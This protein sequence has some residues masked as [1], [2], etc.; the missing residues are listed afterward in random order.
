[1]WNRLELWED[2]LFNSCHPTNVLRFL[3][4]GGVLSGEMQELY[5]MQFTIQDPYFHPEGDVWTHTMLVVEE[6]CK[7]ADREG[8]NYFDRSVLILAAL[9]HDLGKVFTTKVENGRITSHGHEQGG[10]PITQSLLS[11]MGFDN[12]KI[13]LVV[14]LVKEHL[15]PVQLYKQDRGVSD[16]AVRALLERLKPSNIRMLSYLVEADIQGRGGTHPGARTN[17]GV[18]IGSWLRE[19]ANHVSNSPERS[20][21]IV[22]G[23]ELFELGFRSGPIIGFLIKLANELAENGFSKEQIIGLYSYYKSTIVTL[24]SDNEGS[25]IRHT[26]LQQKTL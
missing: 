15:I 16:K 14:P 17:L 5:L 26:L 20:V 13:D 19:L 12:T 25:Y 18:Q 7:I 11:R 6:V 8:L 24:Y 9:C 23:S 1:M 10:V 4:S 22:S 3:L 2:I 21:D